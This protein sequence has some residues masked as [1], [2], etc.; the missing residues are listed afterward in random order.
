[1]HTINVGKFWKQ[2]QIRNH[3]VCLNF[4]D[5]PFLGMKHWQCPFPSCRLRN[6]GEENF[7]ILF[8][9][10]ISLLLR[11]LA[12]V[13]GQRYL[14]NYSI[15]KIDEGLGKI[16]N[17]LL[18]VMMCVC[19]FT[20]TETCIH[21]GWGRSSV[22]AEVV[23]PQHHVKPVVI[24]AC[25]CSMWE[26]EAERQMFILGAYWVWGYMR[27]YSERKRGKKTEQALFLY[28]VQFVL[29]TCTNRHSLQ[30]NKRKWRDG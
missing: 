3:I 1:M 10:C 9:L 26:V 7:Q 8:I 2:L 28:R 24:C 14:L 25:A 21:E 29:R 23:H 27:P 16:V 19:V 13:D 17:I 22:S 30:K 12:A 5:I 15:L 18:V 4:A 11:C 20:C 6:V